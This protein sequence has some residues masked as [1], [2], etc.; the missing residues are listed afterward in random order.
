MFHTLMEVLLLRQSKFAKNPVRY[1]IDTT[2]AFS[3][4]LLHFLSC[5]SHARLVPTHPF[6]I[7][8]F[9]KS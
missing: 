9:I 5:V 2:S 3:I 6:S 4:S 7:V 1:P 8:H